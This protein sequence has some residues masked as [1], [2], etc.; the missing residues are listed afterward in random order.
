MPHCAG[1]IF[2]SLWAVGCVCLTVLCVPHC[3]VCGT[4]LTWPL[5][6]KRV[7]ESIFNK[8]TCHTT[9]HMPHNICHG[10][11]VLAFVTVC[12]CPCICH[13]LCIFAEKL[14]LEKLLLPLVEEEMINFPSENM[15]S[16]VWHGE[17]NM[18][19]ASQR[20]LC[21]HHSVLCAALCT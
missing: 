12:A 9:L 21:T 18:L 7:K 16:C 15:V 17:L 19:Y 20:A 14:E 10:V 1:V 13:N 4:G 6:M 8:V 3:A 2:A 11:H 5:N